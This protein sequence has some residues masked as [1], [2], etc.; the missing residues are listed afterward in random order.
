MRCFNGKESKKEQEA[1]RLALIL[2]FVILIA[3]CTSAVKQGSTASTTSATF[4]TPASMEVRII[5][6]AFQPSSIIVTKGST[7]TWTNEDSVPHTVTSDSGVFDS[8]GIEPGKSF[9][10]TFDTAGTFS[11]HCNFHTQMHGT[12]IVTAN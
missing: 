9:S 11:Y 1:M 2:F 6:F 8:S 7:V 12:V 3:G 5:N 4:A 10:R